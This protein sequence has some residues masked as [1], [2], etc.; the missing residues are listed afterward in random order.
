MKKIMLILFFLIP[1]TTFAQVGDDPMDTMYSYNQ[2]NKAKEVVL[3]H[4]RLPNGEYMNFCRDEYAPM[5]C[6]SRVEALVNLIFREA[7]RNDLDPWLLLGLAIEASNFNPFN[8]EENL[9]SGIM[10]I[11]F[12]TSYRRYDRFFTSIDYR[13]TCRQQPDA[14]QESIIANS[15]TILRASIER[16]SNN[17]RRGLQR[18]IGGRCGNSPRFARHVL[19]NMRELQQ[20]AE[21]IEDVD[22]CEIHPLMCEDVLYGI[23]FDL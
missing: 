12:D 17:V 8:I 1:S 3:N 21:A 14:C 22:V 2:K 20:N 6:E 15:A 13:R 4:L 16:C 5:G 7:R 9:A 23:E 10:G 19:R 18:Y 11:P